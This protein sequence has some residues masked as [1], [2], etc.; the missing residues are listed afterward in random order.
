[1]TKEELVKKRKELIATFLAK[2]EAIGEVYA[3][4]RCP[5]K[6]G[7]IIRGAWNYIKVEKICYN[8]TAYSCDEKE[9][10]YCS[11]FGTIVNKDGVP[12]KNNQRRT[13]FPWSLREANGKKVK[14]DYNS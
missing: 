12:H 13:I 5:V 6:I 11:F 9:V 14:Y 10:P 1:M 3:D 4:E 2:Y 8:S 7:D